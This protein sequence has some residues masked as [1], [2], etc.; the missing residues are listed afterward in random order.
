MMLKEIHFKISAIV[1]FALFFSHC[2]TPE[3]APNFGATEIVVP[4]GFPSID[5]PDDNAYTL[6]RWELGKK[7]FYDPILSKDSSISCASCH[8]QK[9]AFSDEFK[10]SKGVENRLG[11]R[12]TPGLFNLAYHPYFTR[13]GGVPTLEMQIL[14]P[15]QEHNEFDFNI[16]KISE[17]LNRSQT[18][19]EMSQAAYNR[20]PD[21]FV[22]TRALANFE[23]SLLSGNSQYDQYL[24]QNGNLSQEAIQGMDLFFSDKTNC[25]KCHSGFNFS[26]YAF[27]N[28]GL[29]ETYADEGRKR[30]TG[31]A[32]DL[33][34]F[35][36]PSLRNIELTSPYM[37][38]GSIDN[39]DAVIEHYN[40][41]GQ[42][43][44]QKS[45]LIKPLY[46]TNLE[47]QQLK[48]FLISLTDYQFINN[49]KFKP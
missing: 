9:I 27:E 41:G 6:E 28:N 44:I 30:L 17:R 39:L 33:A 24:H 7:L 32:E 8:Q 11:N 3:P 34:L 20:L 43:H 21:H 37:H 31:K 15:I 48:A 29:Y 36:V 4:N 35:K 19:I 12:N 2:K 22:T 47:K 13:E 18:Y 10:V 45:N 16:V 46:L 25:S 23:R 1:F 38:D 5:F 49:E 40:A 14:V 42:N 26:N